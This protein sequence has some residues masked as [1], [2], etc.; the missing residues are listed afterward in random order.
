MIGLLL[1]WNCWFLTTT[2]KDWKAEACVGFDLLAL[3]LFDHKHRNLQFSGSFL[4]SLYFQVD[5][6][7]RKVQQGWS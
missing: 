1:S 2:P 3:S 5:G 6:E 4:S 7:K